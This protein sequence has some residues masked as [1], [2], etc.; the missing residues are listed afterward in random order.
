VFPLE[1]SPYLPDK[2]LVHAAIG[3][4]DLRL[5]DRV[6]AKHDGIE[7]VT[8]AMLAQTRAAQDVGHADR[9]KL[10]ERLWG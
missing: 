9:D 8:V 10:V 2:K 5:A 3:L 1:C 7:L 4:F 6:L